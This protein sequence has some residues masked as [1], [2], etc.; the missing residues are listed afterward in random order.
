MIPSVF[1]TTLPFL[2]ETFIWVNFKYWAPPPLYAFQL[3]SPW[4]NLLRHHKKSATIKIYVNFL[5]RSGWGWK[6]LNYM[7]PFRKSYVL[8]LNWRWWYINGSKKLVLRG[9]FPEGF[10]QA[11]LSLPTITSWL[12]YLSGFLILFC[13]IY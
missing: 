4:Q 3:W 12:S 1:K 6:G 11:F 5:L 2:W 9:P 8:W 10:F 7:S 13:T